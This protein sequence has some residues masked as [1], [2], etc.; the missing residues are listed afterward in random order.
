MTGRE[1]REEGASDGIE[2]ASGS[3]ATRVHRRSTMSLF[4]CTVTRLQLQLGRVSTCHP[5]PRH[6]PLIS[7]FLC[8]H[9]PPEGGARTPAP[10]QAEGSRLGLFFETV[11]PGLSWARRPHCLSV[12][13]NKGKTVRAVGRRETRPT[14]A[15]PN[16][17]WV[18]VDLGGRRRWP[19]GGVGGNVLAHSEHGGTSSS[20]ASIR[21]VKAGRMLHGGSLLEAPGMDGAVMQP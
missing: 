3:Q 8:R 9:E 5:L 13:Q 21:S 11:I 14:A 4:V 20:P 1:A 19:V 12:L 6:P 16:H 17:P 18:G 7:G 15:Q 10:A 2:A